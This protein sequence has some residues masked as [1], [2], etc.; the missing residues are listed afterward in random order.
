MNDYYVTFRSLTSAQRASF[1]AS[2][3]GVRATLIRTPKSLCST[4]CGYALRVDQIFI[5]NTVKILRDAN[6]R[7]E[8]I[9]LSDRTGFGQEVRF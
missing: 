7:F 3:H 1:E 9:L 4:G 6:I 5:Q 2:R 8:K